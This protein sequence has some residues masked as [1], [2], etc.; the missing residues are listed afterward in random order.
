MDILQLKHEL[1]RQEKLDLERTVSHMYDS[2]QSRIHC[3]RSYLW[4]NGT[5]SPKSSRG[6]LVVVPRYLVAEVV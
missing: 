2:P 3:G 1:P 4:Y 5:W 6:S